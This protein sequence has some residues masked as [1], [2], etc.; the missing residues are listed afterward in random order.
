MTKE[1]KLSRIRKEIKD[2]TSAYKKLAAANVAI[3]S[4][5]NVN[6]LT[7]WGADLYSAELNNQ[8]AIQYLKEKIHIQ[9]CNL[10]ACMQDRDKP[11]TETN[12]NETNRHD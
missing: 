9:V 8:S 7:P 6:R 1:K 12:E 10:D 5:R 3:N 2:L 11:S 4:L